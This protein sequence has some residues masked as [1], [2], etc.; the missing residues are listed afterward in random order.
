MRIGLIG[1]GNMASALAHG[2]GVPVIVSDVVH[3]RAAALA[4]D[5]GGEAVAS[6][7]EVAERLLKEAGVP[8]RTIAGDWAARE[9]QARAA[10]AHALG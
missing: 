2:L 8:Y 9:A 4:Q 6:N 10:I 1:A 5:T 3:E 7:A